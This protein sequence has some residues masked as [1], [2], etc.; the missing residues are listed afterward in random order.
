MITVTHPDLEHA[1]PFGRGEVVDIF[2]Q[3]SMAARAHFGVA[4]FTVVGIADL[5]A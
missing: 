2:Q 3:P 1:M 5:A 4:E